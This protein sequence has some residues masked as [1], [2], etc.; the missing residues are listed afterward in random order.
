MKKKAI[1]VAYYIEALAR[2]IKEA[3]PYYADSDAKIKGNVSKTNS[4]PNKPG[5]YI[6]LRKV[7][8]SSY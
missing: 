6:I 2:D 5:V 8:L 7:N 1:T 3:K 4:F